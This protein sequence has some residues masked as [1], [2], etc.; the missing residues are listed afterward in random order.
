MCFLIIIGICSPVFARRYI[1]RDKACLSNVRVIQGV[2]EMYN[3]DSATMIEELNPE[4]M[5]ILIKKRYIKGELGKPEPQCEY[6]SVGNL[7]RNGIIYCPYHGDYNHLIYSEYYKDNKYDQYE[8]LPQNT[9]ESVIELKKDK[10]LKERERLRRKIDFKND[11]LGYYI[12]VAAFVI[13]LV[14]II[15]NIITNHKTKK[16]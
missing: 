10:I 11:L 7:T 1:A 8:K 9:D 13:L 4:T 5:N 14:V 3:M 2:V 15:W 12:P 6:K 16:E